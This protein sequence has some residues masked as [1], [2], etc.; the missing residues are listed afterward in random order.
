M[1]PACIFGF[2]MKNQHKHIYY[3]CAVS[4]CHPEESIEPIVTNEDYL[5]AIEAYNSVVY[6]ILDAA[7]VK[8]VGINAA[9]VWHCCQE[10]KLTEIDP[11]GELETSE[12]HDM[13]KQLLEVIL[14]LIL[15]NQSDFNQMGSSAVA[16]FHEFNPYLRG[17]KNLD[18]IGALVDTS[19][20]A[21]S[22]KQ[23]KFSLKLKK[24]YDQFKHENG[25]S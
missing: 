16:I 15:K 23:I 25:K 10:D 24:K 7:T 22:K 19:K 5:R 17:E 8:Q 3:N 11:L 14:E 13:V 9:N 1:G 21:V 18:Q 4:E 20:Q 12:S 2:A 6:W